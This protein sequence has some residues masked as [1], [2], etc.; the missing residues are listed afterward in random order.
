MT[1]AQKILQ[2]RPSLP[3]DIDGIVI[4]LD[5]LQDQEVLGVTGKNPRWAVAYKFEAEKAR[6][7]I[8]DI[9]VQIGRTGT[10]TP[11]AELE[12]VFLAGS[13]ISRATLHNEEEV[14]RKDIRIGDMVYIEKGGDVIP[15]VVEVLLEE[16]TPQSTAWKMPE[17][18]PACQTPVLR[19]EGEVAVRCPNTVA[20]PEQQLRRIVY[21]AGKHALDIEHMGE[22]VVEQLFHKGFVTK[23]SEI[24]SLNRE[25]LLQLEGF[26]EKSAD[27]LLLSIEKARNVSLT[28]FI[29]ALGIKFVGTGTAELLANKAGEMEVLMA[30]TVEQLIEI[31]GIG[32]KVAN[33]VVEYFSNEK[34]NN[35]VQNLLANG[36]K[37]GV[38]ETKN[39]SGHDFF[40][41]IFVL[42]G[43]LESYTRSSAASLIKE[44]GGKV[45]GS[46]SK[47]T[48]FL[49][50]GD[51][52]G[53]K[54][55][56]AEKLDVKV[57]DEK[58]FAEKL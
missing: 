20:C 5:K 55:D 39:F 13:T 58:E 42:T 50:A 57:L 37:P 41:K 21:F 3:F 38:V 1:F 44:R 54:L 15:K 36:V 6:T 11:V 22:K 53:S 23:V 7:R 19:Q 12:A 43:T 25:Q 47:K 2:L 33:A 8:H 24:F 28:R 35:E 17:T 48:D 51:S 16:R 56:K 45:T 34:Q 29:M 18:C 32:E 30:M 40:G 10:L 4:K 49:L 14:Q 52:P 31:D 9:T 26:K 46:V 27:N